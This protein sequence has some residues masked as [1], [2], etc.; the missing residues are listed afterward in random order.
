MAQE[1]MFWELFPEDAVEISAEPN[2]TD[3]VREWRD[4]KN[5]LERASRKPW[6]E[7]EYSPRM[8]KSREDAL[9]EFC[10]R[11]TPLQRCVFQA[12]KCTVR[13]CLLPCYDDHGRD[14]WMGRIKKSGW[15]RNSQRVCGIYTKGVLTRGQI[16]TPEMKEYLKRRLMSIM[17]CMN[18][19]SAGTF[20]DHEWVS[21]GTI[22]QHVEEVMGMELDHEIGIP[23]VVQWCMPWFSDAKRLNRTW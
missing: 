4:R 11:Q 19:V 17:L 21:E 5:K 10:G 2:S 8:V 6:T 1:G 23:C 22:A 9:R 16:P 7:F 15:V 20:D 13:S 14:L 3:F 12:C 18:W